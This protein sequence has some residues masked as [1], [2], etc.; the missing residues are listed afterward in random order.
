MKVVAK[1]L[2]GEVHPLEPL[3]VSVP[4]RGDDL[5]GGQAKALEDLVRTIEL[6]VELIEGKNLLADAKGH[7]LQRT[8]GGHVVVVRRRHGP[9]AVSEGEQPAHFLP[10]AMLHI[11]AVPFS[12]PVS[13]CLPSGDKAAQVSW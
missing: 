5:L 4:I 13:T 1:H 3:L 11:R 12:L 10:E 9:G 7:A 2:L 6:Q 8:L